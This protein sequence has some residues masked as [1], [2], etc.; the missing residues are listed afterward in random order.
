MNMWVEL[1]ERLLKKRTITTRKI[2]FTD[3]RIVSEIT[4]TDT[5]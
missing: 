5:C 4:F 3:F 2:V 1:E